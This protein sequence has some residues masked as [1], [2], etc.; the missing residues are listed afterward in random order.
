MCSPLLLI[1]IGRVHLLC[2]LSFY[3]GPYDFLSHLF[4]PF[5][6]FQAFMLKNAFVD[7]PILLLSASGISFP[8]A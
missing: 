8:L 7:G 5:V 2:S 1:F 4:F 6:L 3:L